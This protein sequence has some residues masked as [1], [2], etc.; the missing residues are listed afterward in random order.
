MRVKIY[1]YCLK[2]PTEVDGYSLCVKNR[3][4]ASITNNP[5]SLKLKHE[6][7]EQTV[8]NL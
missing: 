6:L 3:K 1:D 8:E 5:D 2:F 4:R 7:G